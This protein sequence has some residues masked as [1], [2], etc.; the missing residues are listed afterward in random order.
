MKKKQTLYEYSDIRLKTGKSFRE[1][2]DDRELNVVQAH[3]VDWLAQDTEFVGAV[4][5]YSRDTIVIM[6]EEYI[7]FSPYTS[8]ICMDYD[9]KGDERFISPDVKGVVG[10]WGMEEPASQLNSTLKI[11]ELS[12]IIRE[13]CI[14]N[15]TNEFLKFLDKNKFCTQKLSPGMPSLCHSDSGNGLVI[16]REINGRTKYFLKGVASI[17]T[18]GPDNFFLF[19]NIFY[20]DHSIKSIDNRYRPHG[21]F[22]DTASK[23]PEMIRHGCTLLDVPRYGYASFLRIFASPSARSTHLHLKQVMDNKTVIRYYCIEGYSLKG[24]ATNVCL[25]GTWI[26]SIPQ[27]IRNP[28]K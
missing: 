24:K 9:L 14:Q 28:S 13:I 8:P 23:V 21:S 12:A 26:Y 6:L 2:D 11:V 15:S 1:Y 20:T 22:L 3:S 16:P 10:A 5:G 7:E 27:C 18:C 25:N 4:D 19:S 17:S